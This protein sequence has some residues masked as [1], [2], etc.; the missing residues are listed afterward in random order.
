[1]RISG[2]AGGV[3][4]KKGIKKQLP[5]GGSNCSVCTACLFLIRSDNIKKCGE[6]GQC[7]NCICIACR[8]EEGD[9][10]ARIVNRE[11]DWAFA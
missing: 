5:R 2:E 3:Y 9:T 11:I 7:A 6:F 8:L 10:S 4:L 1:M